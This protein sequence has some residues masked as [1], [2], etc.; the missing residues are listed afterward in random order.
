MPAALLSVDGGRAFTNAVFGPG[1]SVEYVAT[2]STQAFEHVGFGAGDS[3][4]AET[5]NGAPW[6]MFSNGFDGA[7]IQARTWSG[8]GQINTPIPGS[9]V[10]SPHVFRIDW[11]PAAIEYRIDGN[12]VA[13][14]FE[15]IAGPMRVAASDFNVGGGAVTVDSLSMTPY[16]SPCTFASRI[17]DAG[18]RRDLAVADPHGRHAGWHERRALRPCRQ[19]GRSGRVVDGLRACSHRRCALARRPVS[20]VQR[21][22]DGCGPCRHACAAR[23]HGD[24]GGR[25][26]RGAGGDR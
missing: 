11:T 18:V 14:H 25:H 22:A 10:G 1:S 8:G 21:R 15:A 26:E 2:F 3:G 17:L 20:P 24:R 9:F 12:L 6:A 16:A 4:G 13:T 5:F 19:H 23:C 7:G